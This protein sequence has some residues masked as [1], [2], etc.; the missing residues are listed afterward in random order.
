MKNQVE[1]QS[2]PNRRELL[3]RS[4]LLSAAVMVAPEAMAQGPSSA[5]AHSSAVN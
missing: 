1:P 5:N 3:Q 4:A 2:G